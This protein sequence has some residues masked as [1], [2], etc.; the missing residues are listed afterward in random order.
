[1]KQ[2]KSFNHHESKVT[3]YNGTSN[4]SCD[5]VTTLYKVKVLEKLEL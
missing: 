2:W 5:L 3:S 4:F 1:M